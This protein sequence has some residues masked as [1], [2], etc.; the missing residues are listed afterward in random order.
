M[1]GSMKD[2]F[3]LFILPAIFWL[4]VY[5]GTKEPVRHLALDADIYFS[6][7]VKC[8]NRI[9]AEIAKAKKIDV[10]MYSLTNMLITTALLDAYK[11]GVDIRVVADRGMS[12]NKHSQVDELANAGIPV[13][14]SKKH[15]IEH[16]KFAVFDDRIVVSGSYNWTVAATESNS[17]NCLFFEQPNNEFSNRFEEL[18]E[19]YSD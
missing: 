4:G 3:I 9:V 6:P 18:W 13:R 10:A 14:K 17:E 7:G 11:R 19:I 12:A 5:S 16:N 2:K 1:W 8:E 15:K